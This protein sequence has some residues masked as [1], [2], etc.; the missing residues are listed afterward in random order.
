MEFALIHIGDFVIIKN[1]KKYDPSSSEDVDSGT[2]KSVDS[3]TVT[4]NVAGE[5]CKVSL[6]DITVRKAAEKFK[7]GDKVT[8]KNMKKYDT[9][10]KTDKVEGVVNYASGRTVVV[11]YSHGSVSAEEND[12]EKK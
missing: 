6:S 11:S 9:L 3:G 7:K 5:L 1:M 12:V 10:F 2:V 8:V 4:V